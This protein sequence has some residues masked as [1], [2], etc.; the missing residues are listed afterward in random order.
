MSRNNSRPPSRSGSIRQRLGDQPPAPRPAGI[1]PG[2]FD[3]VHPQ[4]G[5]FP[6]PDPPPQQVLQPPPEALYGLAATLA[7]VPEQGPEPGGPAGGSLAARPARLGATR[8]VPLVP[9][10]AVPPPPGAFPAPPRGR[11][12]LGAVNPQDP[13]SLADQRRRRPD[14]GPMGRGPDGEVPYGLALELMNDT[15]QGPGSFFAGGEPDPHQSLQRQPRDA[16]AHLGASLRSRRS[17]APLPGVAVGAGSSGGGALGPPAPSASPGGLAGSRPGSAIPQQP[18][19]DPFTVMELAA[20]QEGLPEPDYGLVA[21]LRNRAPPDP[22][23][24]EY[25]LA[26]EVS[27]RRSRSPSPLPPLRARRRLQP[28]EGLSLDDEIEARRLRDAGLDPFATPGDP[29]DLAGEQLKVPR[30]LL[31]PYEPSQQPYPEGDDDMRVS[32]DD[33]LWGLARELGVDLD[34]ARRLKE[35]REKQGLDAYGRPLD[36]VEPTGHKYVYDE[37]TGMLVTTEGGQGDGGARKARQYIEDEVTGKI[38]KLHSRRRKLF[39]WLRRKEP[40]LMED[41]E[42]EDD[43]GFRGGLRRSLVRVTTFFNI[44]G[45]FSEGLL[46]GFA[47]LNL[48]MTYM[49]YANKGMTR[50]LMYYGPISL[51]CNRMYYCLLV[52]SI[53]S[54]TSRLARDKLRDFQPRSLWLAPVGYGAMV[55]YV[56]AYIA[57]TLCTPLDDELTY[58][59]NRNPNWYLLTFS[60]S[61][62]KRY[63]VWQL[64][65]LIRTILVGLAWCCTVYQLSPLIFDATLRFEMRQYKRHLARA[66][67]AAGAGRG[68]GAG[69]QAGGGGAVVAGVPVKGPA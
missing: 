56:G 6:A 68:G 35:E 67:G 19:L 49:L 57:S 21:E 1:P 36:Q 18:A 5:P 69:A 59:S 23:A 12:P 58:E 39:A 29:F 43:R 42:D 11:A 53:I 66:G 33:E 14:N 16:A 28:V 13:F 46:A 40:G 10:P 24:S 27:R 26:A 38:Y 51:S 41:S 55:L 17:L 32:G 63:S 62:K 8:A 22:F 54:S 65:N 25:G 3:N 50:F 37:D 61:F 60:S 64:L 20:S 34:T 9:M 4:E 31:S 15:L 48:F 2:S 52:L 47:L 7:G 44:L 45:L 30:E